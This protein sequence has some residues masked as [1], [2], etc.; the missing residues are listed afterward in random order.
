MITPHVKTFKNN[1]ERGKDLEKRW[2]AYLHNRGFWVRFMHPAPDGS[3]PFDILALKGAG[4][5]GLAMVCAF[6][7]KTLSGKR[8]PLGRVE[9]NQL[10]AFEL[11]NRKGIHNTYFVV[12]TEY[13]KVYLLPS[14]YV[15]K[16]YYDGNKSIDMEE[17]GY[18][19]F[20]LE[21]DIH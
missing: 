7:C 2:M 5:Q 15:Q 17:C 6:D 18:G 10:T 12:E 19:H 20:H 9:D 8:F 11:L 13:N 14:D 16:C 21:Q 3:Q 1:Q 4:N